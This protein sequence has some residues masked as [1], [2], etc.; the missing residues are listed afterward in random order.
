MANLPARAREPIMPKSHTNNALTSGQLA[1][2]EKQRV[3]LGSKKY[4][5]RAK[6]PGVALPRDMDKMK[7]VYKP[8]EWATRTGR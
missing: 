4:K 1:F 7:S 3:A 6:N 5:P 8:P 2:T